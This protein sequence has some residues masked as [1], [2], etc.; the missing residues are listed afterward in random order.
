MMEVSYLCEIFGK[1]FQIL[2]RLQNMAGKL[3]P[4]RCRVE[5]LAEH[6]PRI[7]QLVHSRGRRPRENVHDGYR[8]YLHAL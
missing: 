4:L 2:V 5:L 7:S 8:H 3:F 1:A 6:L